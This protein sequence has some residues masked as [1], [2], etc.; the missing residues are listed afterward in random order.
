MK[1]RGSLFALL[2]LLAFQGP[3]ID[4]Q[5]TGLVAAYNFDEGV[6]TAFSDAS[7]TGNAGTISGGATWTTGRFG[8]ALS[9]AGVD[10]L[11]TV[12]DSASLHLSAGMTLEAW[13]YPVAVSSW[14]TIVLKERPG[15]L[16]YALYGNT[17]TNRPSGEVATSGGQFDVRGASQLGLN[18]WTH[19]ATTYDGATLRLFVNGAQVRTRAVSGA[20]VT[21]S[22]PLRI[23][24]NLVWGEY[25]KGRIDDVRIYNRAV[26]AAQIQ[27]DMNTP[28]GSADTTAPSAV[29]TGPAGGSTVS[30]TAPVSAAASDNV[31][32]SGVQF[33]LDGAPLGTE[34]TSSPF[35][36]SWDT[37]VA[38][39]GIHRLSATAR[40]A[41]GNTGLAPEVAVTVANP[42]ILIIT[43]PAQGSSIASSTVNVAYATSG[44]PTG[45]DRVR[46][47]LDNNADVTDLTFDGAYQLTN[48]PAGSHVLNGYLARADD[49][50]IAGSDAAPVSFV[51]ADTTPPHV[52][53][54]APSDG[55]T[56]SGG[57][58][59][60]ADASDDVGVASVQF[61]L[62]GGNL[63]A[64]DTI[65]P[66]SVTWDSAG[67]SNGA[68]ALSAKARDAAG[69][70]TTS[71][72]LNVTVS[73][74]DTTAPVRSNGSPSGSLP[75]GTTSTAISL[76]TNEASVCRYSTSANIA[77]ANMIGS[78]NTADNLFHSAQVSGLGDGSTYNYYARCSD[79]AG[80]INAND[81]PI[82]FSI[83]I[84]IPVPL[85]TLN[86]HT[87]YG[88][89]S[90]RIISWLSPQ[91]SAYGQAADIAWDF[92]LNRVPNDGNGLKAYLTNSYLTKDTLQPS[93][94]M[95]NPADMN[96]AFIDSA[97]LYYAYSGDG[98]VIDFARASA[99]YHLQNGMTPAT[100][101][102]ASVPYAS[103]CGNCPY[104][105][106][107]NT[108]DGAGYIQP[109]KVG[110]L[111]YGLLRLFEVTGDFRYRDAAMNAANALAGHIRTGS[112]TQSPWPFRVLA[113]TNAVKEDYTADV[114]RPIML[115]DELARL[116]LGSVSAY[117]AA[118]STAWNWL[119][120]YPMQNNVWSNFFEDVDVQPS[121]NNYNQYIAGETA[122]YLLQ[123]PEFDPAWQAHVA[124][125]ISWIE[126]TFGVAQFGANT[127][128][129]QM[130]FFYPMGSH[131]SRYGA[132]TAA[133]AELTGNAAAKENAYRALN[134]ATYMI[135][136]S[137]TGQ[138][139][140]GPVN[141]TV[142]FTDGYGD[143]IRH[144]LRAMG[145]MPEWAEASHA[146]LL[147][148]TSVVKNITFGSSRIDYLTADTNGT[149]V[150]KLTFTPTTV[151]LNNVALPR[152]SDLNSEGW[153]YD[154]TSKVLRI[155]RG[156]GDQIVISGQ[157]P[158]P[159]T[160]APTAS[161]T[162]PAANSTV[163]ATV[164]VSANASD[165]QGVV[166]VQFLLD[167][168]TLGAEDFAA[169]YA[170]NW[171]TTTASNGGHV[172]SA[173]ARDAAGNIGSSSTVAVTVTNLATATIDFNNLTNTGAAFSGQYP[174]GVVD[175]GSNAWY[176]S[177]PWGQFTTNSISFLNSGSIAAS[178]TFI[179]SSRLLRISAYN[180]G[181]GSSTVSL[182]C[183]GNPTKSV[184]V[185]ANQAVTIDTGWTVNCST[186]TIGS[187][188][189]WNTNFDDLVYDLAP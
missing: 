77:F 13:V 15:Q 57:T 160:T 147:K 79:I 101:S 93:G 34:D 108:K 161:L 142:W 104:Y 168:N 153:V 143:Y 46:F 156:N 172:L 145:A 135:S 117:Q 78:F 100:W 64:A 178:L 40:D 109:D 8:G 148:S 1:I 110:E 181:T 65:A 44:D 138:I 60:S 23:G 141:G 59:V 9:F 56:V 136:S 182:A 81:Y 75:S 91:S 38:T 68:H 132:V 61:L 154:S 137:P 139:I 80:N 96:A 165:D 28:V 186:V 120:T 82:S 6:G 122:Y 98:R 69:N 50:K 4:A 126:Q 22:N 41:M 125:I 128:A 157:P 113:S 18:V 95:H 115:F 86:G 107:S 164:T 146:H 67:T 111:G 25:F 42:P 32:V 74:L 159:D 35:A 179:K 47:R 119:M 26:S 114:I 30:G 2:A 62:D 167:G 63:G 89:Q 175:W 66:Y 166:G 133:Y 174:S 151:L 20:L 99:D 16:A 116:N 88:D 158:P 124:G 36:V 183:S 70:T 54:T 129:E 130:V 51:V 188:N 106:G 92:L 55:A 5:G 76:L 73:N 45:V 102:W 170:V 83:A 185:A 134:W 43:G 176:L 14:R 85:G 72:L 189:S 97:I 103:G 155:R 105:D 150:L 29:I 49:S 58:M 127:I 169:P 7:G 184:S 10:G 48:V 177:G 11:A 121:L 52:A 180:G 152:R 84:F 118:R 21:S 53:V 19:V 140:Y 24:G 123:H 3:A 37:R 149:E 39:N 27:T 87:V 171:D 33:L 173:R 90:G 187:S 94:W 12:A 17:D 131:T 31:G 71:S 162:A 163:S 112:A 144:F